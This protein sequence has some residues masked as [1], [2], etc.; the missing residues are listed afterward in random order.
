MKTKPEK[1]EMKP[2]AVAKP[3]A[4]TD[5]S[6][7]EQASLLK[8]YVSGGLET[9]PFDAPAAIKGIVREYLI[10]KGHRDVPM[11]AE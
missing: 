1:T 6:P 4:F 3:R 8:R 10:A 2:T 7:D 5:F 9:L 11:V